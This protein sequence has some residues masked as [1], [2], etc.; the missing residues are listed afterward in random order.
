MN[1]IAFTADPGNKQYKLFADGLLV[2]TLIMMHTNL[3][4]ILLE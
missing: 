4:L 2:A 1:T 3:L